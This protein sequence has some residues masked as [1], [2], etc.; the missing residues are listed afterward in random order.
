MLNTS[1]VSPESSISL[2]PEVWNQ[3]KASAVPA[4]MRIWGDFGRMQAW[5]GNSDLV[6]QPS[7][8]SELP[9]K[10]AMG[11]AYFTGLWEKKKNIYPRVPETS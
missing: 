1:Q 5:I 7:P 3:A 2:I 8:T 10:R 9:I 4:S 6:L 11:N